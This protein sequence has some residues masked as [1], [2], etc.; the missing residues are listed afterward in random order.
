MTDVLIII[1]DILWKIQPLKRYLQEHA[2]Q[3]N[4]E[5]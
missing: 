1:Q 3:H 2:E 4:S 5:L